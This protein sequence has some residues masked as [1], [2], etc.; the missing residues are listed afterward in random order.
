MIAL[1]TPYAEQVRDKMIKKE[2]DA[3]KLVKCLCYDNGKLVFV[4]CVVLLL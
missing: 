4:I 1:D 2:E 3:E